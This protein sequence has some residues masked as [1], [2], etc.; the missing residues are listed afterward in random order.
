MILQSLSE[1]IP[2]QKHFKCTLH[3][4]DSFERRRQRYIGKSE[5]STCLA[6][7][8]L[9]INHEDTLA[10][11][12]IA[13]F[14]G[15]Q[16]QDIVSKS[17]DE[18]FEFKFND[19]IEKLMLLD[20]KDRTLYELLAEVINILGIENHLRRYHD[21]SQKLENVNSLLTFAKI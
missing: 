20:V 5:V 12:E 10:A 18:S 4:W 21:S 11:A 8:R 16:P 2:A 15:H 6:G 17:F 14:F 19:Q 1:Q 7:F 9:A 13:I 3:L